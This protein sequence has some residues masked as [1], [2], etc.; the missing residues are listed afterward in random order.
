[1]CD[2]GGGNLLN[3][4]YTVFTQCVEGLCPVSNSYFGRDYFP[5]SAMLL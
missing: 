5:P 3:F 1:M 4:V 2:G